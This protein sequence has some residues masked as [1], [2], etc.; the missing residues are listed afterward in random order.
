MAGSIKKHNAADNTEP[1]KKPKTKS[2]SGFFFLFSMIM[3]SWGA[4][5]LGTGYIYHNY[6]DA[7]DY[8]LEF[9]KEKK[10]E[11]AE[12]KSIENKQQIASL[13]SKINEI[14]A[15]IV[16]LKAISENSVKYIE[17]TL[18]PRLP[19]EEAQKK[20][21]EEEA[22]KLSNLTQ[23]DPNFVPP[24]IELATPT[25]VKTNEP[26]LPEIQYNQVVEKGKF[27]YMDYGKEELG[28]GIA[29]VSD[30]TTDLEEKVYNLTSSL[31]RADNI[32]SI[33]LLVISAVN[34]KDAV[35]NSQRFDTEIETLRNVADDQIIRE[36][37]D[38]LEPHSKVGV[39]S[40][41]ALRDDFYDIIDDVLNASRKSKKEL[42]LRDQL[43]VKF[44]NI[45]SI[46]KIGE[47]TEG[48]ETEDKLARVEGYLNKYNLRQAVEEMQTL[49]GLP[50]KIAQDW[51]DKATSLLESQN[52]SEAIYQHISKIAREQKNNASLEKKTFVN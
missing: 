12:E 37:I 23:K 45:I 51:L 9:K 50:A 16:E 35:K 26:P 22:K 46:R 17:A 19:D 11:R 31:E 25:I 7:I 36:N 49:E 1:V 18:P 15:Q 28:A 44:S 42:G 34:L 5:V 40:Y 4:I 47:Y 33:N 29:E 20:A 24:G 48:D 10:I 38:I 30:R 3:F 41:S 32:N 13:T 39:K 43:A 27:E 2:Y 6:K 8:A 14:N 52:A 21:Q